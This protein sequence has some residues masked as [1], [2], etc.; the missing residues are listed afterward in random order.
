MAARLACR[1]GNT[2]VH[3]CVHL[4]L[5][6]HL[7]YLQKF[8][9]KCTSND[10]HD[11]DTDWTIPVQLQGPI[12]QQLIR[13]GRECALW[14]MAVFTMGIHVEHAQTAHTQQKIRWGVLREWQGLGLL[15]AYWTNAAFA[16]VS[17]W[18][19][20]FQYIASMVFRN[21]KQFESLMWP[22]RPKEMCVE[23]VGQKLSTI[24]ESVRH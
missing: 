8:A 21:Q 13:L 9:P 14:R 20:I 1:P 3:Y 5:R 23:E 4:I 6:S 16:S 11:L 7:S 18:Q 17:F 19:K 22:A 10:I 12:Y 2:S 24:F 15:R